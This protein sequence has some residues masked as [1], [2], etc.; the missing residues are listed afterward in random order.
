MARQQN[1]Q[2]THHSWRLLL[3]PTRESL[4]PPRAAKNK[5]RNKKEGPPRHSG[6]DSDVSPGPQGDTVGFTHWA[7]PPFLWVTASHPGKAWGPSLAQPKISKLGKCPVR[8]AGGM[9]I[10]GHWQQAPPAPGRQATPVEAEPSDRAYSDPEALWKD[11]ATQP[12]A[13]AT[14]WLPRVWTQPSS[15][16]CS[17]EEVLRSTQGPGDELPTKRS[18]PLP[19]GLQSCE[20]PHRLPSRPLSCVPWH[21]LLCWDLPPK[22]LMTIPENKILPAATH[23]W[24][25]PTLPV[26]THPPL[27][28]RWLPTFASSVSSGCLFHFWVVDGVWKTL[29]S[30]FKLLPKILDYKM[31][32]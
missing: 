4:L 15:L 3:A 24:F 22:T 7:R 8:W 20:Q 19:P 21:P 23:T 25:T 14:L 11:W 30:F 26:G 2:P 1:E 5:L 27:C 31:Q 6:D 28:Q 17:L 9:S 16:F 10:W 13:S 12:E 18:P 29:L 32:W